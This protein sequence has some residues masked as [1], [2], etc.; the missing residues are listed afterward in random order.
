M[1]SGLN[2]SSKSML[3]T[4]TRRPEQSQLPIVPQF[5]KTTTILDVRLEQCFIKG[6]IDLLSPSILELFMSFSGKVEQLG[7]DAKTHNTIW[8][9]LYPT[10]Q[11]HC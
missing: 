2:L 7:L 3:K 11:E 5:S 1:A 6:C 10:R 8:W 9:V 4:Q